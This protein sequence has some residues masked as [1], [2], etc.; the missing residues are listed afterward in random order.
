MRQTCTVSR[1]LVLKKNKTKKNCVSLSETTLVG[2]PWQ[3][4]NDFIIEISVAARVLKL[5]N[6]WVA[7]A[8]VNN[9][10]VWT[11]TLVSREDPEEGF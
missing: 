1:R 8:I 6:C 2:M 11:T 5:G 9:Y 10:Q 3:L 7:A 4:K